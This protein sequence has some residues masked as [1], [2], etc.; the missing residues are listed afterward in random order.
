MRK[1]AIMR[2]RAIAGSLLRA[3]EGETSEYKELCHQVNQEWIAEVE[4]C[5]SDPSYGGS[6]DAHTLTSRE[7]S[8]L[9]TISKGNDLSFGC[10]MRGCR[11]YGLN[12]MW[13]EHKYSYHFKCP[14]CGEDYK[15]ASGYKDALPYA[16][17]LTCIDPQT[18]LQQA[19][20]CTWP[21][22]QDM[23]WLNKQI[24]LHA[25][26]VKTPE[27]VESW[28]NGNKIAL[29]KLLAERAIPDSFRRIPWDTSIEN[30]FSSNWNYEVYKEQ[31]F[32][33]GSVLSETDANKPPYSNWNE[34]TGLFAN[35]V[36]PSRAIV[37]RSSS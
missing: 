30:R 35:A 17:V 21:P 20:P 23:Q 16:F 22:S 9:T 13:V 33:W 37:Q 6:A 34:L 36:A 10:R 3:Y 31:G 24:E 28:N 19:L 18:G 29:S 5:A 27:D 2:T 25:R 32:F 1:L 11:F 12:D 8:Y 7:V 26:Q 15:P 14:K 4:K